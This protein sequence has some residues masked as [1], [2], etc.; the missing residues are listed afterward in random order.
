M[1]LIYEVERPATGTS[2]RKARLNSSLLLIMDY[3]WSRWRG[4]LSPLSLWRNQRVRWSI[5]GFV[6]GWGPN[7]WTSPFIDRRELKGPFHYCGRHQRNYE[8]LWGIR[9]AQTDSNQ[10]MISGM[11]KPVRFLSRNKKGRKSW[12][13][14]WSLKSVAFSRLLYSYFYLKKCINQLMEIIIINSRA[15]C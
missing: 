9:T 13:P 1:Q 7:Q 11:F 2:S 3:L 14:P 8:Y 5:K 10:N 12:L 15:S 4:P 6:G